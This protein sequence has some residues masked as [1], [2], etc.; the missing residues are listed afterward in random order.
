MRQL[1]FA[2][3]LMTGLAA[4][5]QAAPPAPT[6]HVNKDASDGSD[7]AARL[8][9]DL[10]AAKLAVQE[11]AV[12]PALMPF[13]SQVR[14]YAAADRPLAEQALGVL[15]RYR[16]RAVL[17]GP[18]EV[19][20]AP[21]R[22]DVFVSLQDD[23]G[24]AP[25]LVPALP[26]EPSPFS[27]PSLTDEAMR[28]VFDPEDTSKD[29][30]KGAPPAARAFLA[31][32]KQADAIADDLQ[33]CLAYPDLPGSQ[34][35]RE[36]VTALCELGNEPALTTAEVRAF[37]E[38]GDAA[39]LDARLAQ[40]LARQF[41]AGAARSEVLHRELDGLDGD[42]IAA[43]RELAPQSP[44]ALAAEARHG[45]R[46]AW[47]ARGDELAG[48][49]SPQ[50]F[51]AMRDLASSAIASA[52]SAVRLEPTLLPAWVTLIELGQ[53][54]GDEA[55]VES[56]F[57]AAAKL[58]A[59]SYRVNV[60]RMNALRPRWGGSLAGMDAFADAVR[61]LV[62]ARP[63]LAIVAAMPER[64]RGLI[65]QEEGNRAGMARVLKPVVAAVPD[66]GS[67]EILA[68]EYVS[69]VNDGRWAGLAYGLEAARFGECAACTRNAAAWDLRGVAGD[70]DWALVHV[71]RQLRMQPGDLMAQQLLGDYR[72]KQ[73]R[74]PE[75]IRILEGALAKATEARA[76]RDLLE[77][78]VAATR[79]GGQAAKSAQY[80]RQL[81]Q[82]FPQ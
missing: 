14:Y 20:G 40:G 60:A 30:L 52:Q 21:G 39:G 13:I 17:V 47:S 54:T 10:G 77:L 33:R 7:H 32:A 57:A 65:A 81:A 12:D 70:L 24:S 44:Y 63:L 82:E 41:A 38:R 68:P 66:P 25:A 4:C 46:A 35:P 27:A 2:V 64:E 28:L 31:A 76:R 36:L 18:E 75:A 8:E 48:D 71:E 29:P 69:F 72:A 78:L 22:V 59:G 73:G 51:A 5:A 53:L 62:A 58:D 43:W 19:T 50:Q 79:D 26:A 49:T 15:Q 80:A 42:T 23:D 34:W 1:L 6:V 55:L 74:F 11:E 3:L 37:V 67:F 61:K 45:L 56:S 16:T 9:A